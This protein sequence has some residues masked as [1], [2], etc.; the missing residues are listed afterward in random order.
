MAEQQLAGSIAA[1]GFFGLN[2]Q[3]SSVQ[4]SNGYALEAFNCVIDK[5]GRIGARKG[6]TPVNT[7]AASTGAFRTIYEAVTNDGNFV[8]SAANNKIYTGTTTLKEQPIVGVNQHTGT[9]TQSGTTITVSAT[10]HGYTNGSSVRLDFTSGTAVSGTYVITG[11]GTSNTFTVTAAASA[12]TSGSVQVVNVLTYA[13]TSDNWQISGLPYDAGVTTSGHALIVQEDQEALV[14]HKISSAAHSHV[15]QYGI[16]RLGDVATL[17][18]NHTT[19]SFKPNVVLTAY[20]RVWVANIA[21]DR[22]TVYFSDLLDPAEWVA[23]SAGYI[24]LGEVVPNNDSIVALA[25]YNGFLIIFCNRHIVVY[26]NPTNPASLQLQDLIVGTG[27]IARDSVQSIG[28]DL[29]FLSQTGV[30]SLQR[31]IQEKSLP[32]RDISKNVRDDLISYANTESPANI[33]AVYYPTDAFYLLSFP[34]TGYTYC[35]DTRGTLENGAARTTIWRGINPTAFCLTQ[36]RQLYIGKAGYIGKYEG[37]T[38]NSVVYRMSYYTNYFDFEQPTTT[39]MLKRINVVAIGGSSQAISFKWAFD[40]ISNY[41]SG[42]V[43]LDTMTV[44]E[45]GIAEYNIAEYSN[46]IALDNA[47]INAGG[48][49]KVLQLGFEADINNASLSIQ[50]IDFSLKAGKTLI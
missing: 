11:V 39:K 15:G 14:F 37:H 50:K 4:L 5:Y 40:Y 19:T 43:S 41:S 24:N 3:D 35:F 44:Y 31:V 29:L 47:Q 42:V 46:G 9:Y 27:C 49:G 10:S 32:F 6:W 33:K 12:T 8:I 21:G 25:A 7:V 2:T 20:G 1:P 26:A 38:D 30:Q 45:Y 23:G 22:N 28:T 17:P 16:Q 36:D 18:A 48:S 34:S 13:I